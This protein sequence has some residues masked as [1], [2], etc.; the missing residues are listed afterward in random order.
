VGLKFNGTHHLVIYADDDNL[1]V[2]NINTMQNTEIMLDLFSDLE[3][4]INKSQVYVHVSSS[5]YRT[6][7]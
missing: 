5:A 4:N 1:F 7:P 6:K 3:I 2:R